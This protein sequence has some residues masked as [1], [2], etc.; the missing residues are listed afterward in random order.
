MQGSES[1]AMESHPKV[2][3][4]QRFAEVAQSSGAMLT[5]LVALF[6][7]LVISVVALFRSASGD[8]ATVAGAAFT[9]MGTIAGGYGGVRIGAHG[10]EQSDRSAHE[11]QLVLERVA[12][13]GG[14]GQVKDARQ[15]VR[16]DLAQRQ[17]G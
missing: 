16:E 13:K 9:A 4:S 12:E 11:T 2:P 17:N 5:V 7:M 14:E 15:E 1:Q 10:K 6:F 8:V 3:L